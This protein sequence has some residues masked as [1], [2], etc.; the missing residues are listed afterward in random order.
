LVESGLLA[1]LRRVIT[2]QQP[3]AAACRDIK[4]LESPLSFSSRCISWACCSFSLSLILASHLTKT[5]QQALD[6]ERAAPPRQGDRKLWCTNPVL[7]LLGP[8][9]ISDLSPQSGP[10]RTLTLRCHQSRFV[11]TRPRGLWPRRGWEPHAMGKR[12]DVQSDRVQIILGTDRYDVGRPR[13][14]TRH[15]TSPYLPPSLHGGSNGFLW[16]YDRM[17]RRM[18]REGKGSEMIAAP[19]QTNPRQTTTHQQGR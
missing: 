10:Q 6:F 8:R 14:R 2:F 7:A 12:P 5:W 13:R 9:D 19:T 4:R 16:I 3:I 1:A 18:A 11:S 17:G 15:L